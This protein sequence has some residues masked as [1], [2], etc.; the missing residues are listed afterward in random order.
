ML[1]LY[2]D[3]SIAADSG[4]GTVGD[5]YGDLEYAL[6]QTEWDA[7]GIRVNIKVGT[8]EVL[9]AELSVAA[10]DTTA[11]GKTTAWQGV[12]GAPIV[13]EGYSTVAGDLAG[14]NTRA[15]ISGG[16]LVSIWDNNAAAGNY[17]VFKNLKMGNCGNNSIINANDYCLAYACEFHTTTGSAGHAWNCDTGSTIIRCWVHDILG[18]A[19]LGTAPVVIL[20][21]LQS[22]TVG[23]VCSGSSGGYW[24]RNVIIVSTAAGDGISCNNVAIIEHNVVFHDGSIATGAG[25][26]IFATAD[27]WIA[28]IRNNIVQGF[29][30]S[31]GVGFSFDTASNTTIAF[32][33]GNS[34]YDCE[35]AFDNPNGDIHVGDTANE[36]LASS[37]FTDAANYDFTTVDVGNIKEGALPESIYNS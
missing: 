32:F 7:T 18:S 14:T 16:G 5:P 37:P 1:E 27:R 4:A 35:T 29:S 19:V 22:D 10:A 23:A 9:A 24:S 20:C 8:A 12:I 36:T 33:D 15:E 31:G 2:V 34:V 28:T 13:F 6:E 11:P 25:Y 3:P 30:G 21:W 17:L 26:G